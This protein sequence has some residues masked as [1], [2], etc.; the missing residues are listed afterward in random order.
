MYKI[1]CRKTQPE[2]KYRRKSQGA[3]FL[4]HPVQQQ[5]TYIQ[6]VTTRQNQ[7][8]SLPNRQDRLL[9]FCFV[10]IFSFR[11][12]TFHPILLIWSFVGRILIQNA[13]HLQATATAYSYGCY[14]SPWWLL[15]GNLQTV[16]S[17]VKA[18]TS[19]ERKRSLL[20]QKSLLNQYHVSKLRRLNF[21]LYINNVV[22][23]VG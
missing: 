5:A 12:H 2:R 15:P 7:Y 6:T 1:L 14:H 13:H 19:S 9:D 8:C 11:W 4:T 20:I 16:M 18:L 17:V 21:I 22:V 10:V 3:T 23:N